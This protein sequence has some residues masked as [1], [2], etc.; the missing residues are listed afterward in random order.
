MSRWNC[1][2]ALINETG[3]KKIAHRTAGKRVTR[4][5]G[6]C[7][8]G[9]FFLRRV[10]RHVPG[11]GRKPVVWA[12][13]TDA[14][15]GWVGARER[16][17]TD[18]NLSV[19]YRCR[20]VIGRGRCTR[21]IC[22]DIPTEGLCVST[23]INGRQRAELTEMNTARSSTSSEMELQSDFFHRVPERLINVPVNNLFGRRRQQRP[24][25]PSIITGIRILF[26]VFNSTVFI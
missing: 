13:E 24:G 20:Y 14:T 4:S 1:G 3:W 17:K 10:Y 5:V 8:N 7:P 25:E 21:T 16:E 15:D 6:K 19:F 26:S 22:P 12:G 23:V 18:K 11:F 2:S 9:S